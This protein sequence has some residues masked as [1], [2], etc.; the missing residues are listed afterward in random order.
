[1]IILWQSQVLIVLMHAA[2][3]NAAHSAMYHNDIST[4]YGYIQGTTYHGAA[5]R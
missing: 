1:M 4:V 3:Y 5:E 2:D